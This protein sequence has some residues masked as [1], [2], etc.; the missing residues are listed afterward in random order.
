MDIIHTNND[1]AANIERIRNTHL[2]VL[3]SER[4]ARDT[5]SAR[6]CSASGGARQMNA[7]A[8]ADEAKQDAAEAARPVKGSDTVTGAAAVDAPAVRRPIGGSNVYRV[9]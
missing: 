6:E 5:P 3:H 4:T 2:S 8:V 1:M 9:D 7:L